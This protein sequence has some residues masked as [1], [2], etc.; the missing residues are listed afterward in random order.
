MLFYVPN[1]PEGVGCQEE[2]DG[3]EGD[4]EDEA[5]LRVQMIAD[6]ALELFRDPCVFIFS[7]LV[8][9]VTIDS[10]QVLRGICQCRRLGYEGRGGAGQVLRGVEAGHVDHREND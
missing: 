7:I 10:Y 2:G 1:I 6:I 3:A 8:R 9:N 5:Q 4:E